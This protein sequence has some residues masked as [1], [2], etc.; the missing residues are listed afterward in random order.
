MD[1]YRNQVFQDRSFNLEEASFVG[2]TLKNC[3]LYYSGGDFDWVESRFE[4]CRFHWRGPAKNTVAL[5]QAM[6]ALQQQMPPQNLMPAPPAQKP[7]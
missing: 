7:N 3:D 5:L 1:T 4:A 2:C 6:G